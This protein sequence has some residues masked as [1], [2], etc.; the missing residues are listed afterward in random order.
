MTSGA[1]DRPGLSVAPRAGA[2]RPQRPLGVRAASATLINLNGVRAAIVSM[3]ISD[4]VPEIIMFAGD[5]FL[6]RTDP[7]HPDLTY[8]QARPYRADGSLVVELAGARA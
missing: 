7:D 6:L 3:V 2:D 1:G 4:E 8:W 5:P